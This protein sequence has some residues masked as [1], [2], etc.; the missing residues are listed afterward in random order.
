VTNIA[1]LIAAV[2]IAWC[3]RQR[4][5]AT[6]C[7]LRLYRIPMATAVN[8]ANGWRTTSAVEQRCDRE[9]RADGDVTTAGKTTR[10]VKVGGV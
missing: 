5:R 4:V 7:C 1:S 10:S 3:N 8:V 6:I 9:Q 2:L